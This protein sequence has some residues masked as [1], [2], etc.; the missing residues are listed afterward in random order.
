MELSA[1]ILKKF[2]LFQSFD[3][4]ELEGFASKL[5]ILTAPPKKQI[6]RMGAEDNLSYLLIEGSIYLRATDNKITQLNETM[7]ASASPIAQ[8]L[9]RRYDVIAKTTIHYLA[10]DNSEISQSTT[11]TKGLHVSGEAEGESTF[12]E[13]KMIEDFI[14]DLD[15]ET[16][17]LPSCPEIVFKIRD[18]LSKENQS[19]KEIANIIQSDPV[20]TAKLIKIA[21]SALYAGKSPIENC[22]NALVRIGLKTTQNLVTSFALNEVFSNQSPLLQ[23]RIQELW[24]HSTYVAA[25]CHVMASKDSRFDPDQAMLAGLTHDI[26]VVAILHYAN[27]HID[28]VGKPG[29]LE[30]MINSLRAQTGS[31]ILQDWGFPTEFIIC[32]LEAEDWFRDSGTEP[33]YCDLIILSQLHSFIGTPLSTNKPAINEIPAFHKLELGDLTPEKTFQIIKESK[34]QITQIQS[35]LAG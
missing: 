19:T 26:G 30:H 1:Q 3:D 32:A 22:A 13:N 27:N 28:E 21:N 2:D 25:I 17:I 9:P 5:E 16:L 23:K 34:E 29:V 12:T 14:N 10:I 8:L 6:I 20:I 15:A 7:P 4:S 18:A 24:K 35:I 31:M 33:D 11:S